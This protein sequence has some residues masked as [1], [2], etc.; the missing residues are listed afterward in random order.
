MRIK[1]QEFEV[2]PGDP[3]QSDKLNRKEP[4]EILTSLIKSFKGPCVLAVDAEWGHGKTTFLRFWMQYLRDKKFPVI[5]FNAWETDYSDDPLLSLT[6]EL[7]EGLKEL[8]FNNI[9]LKQLNKKGNELLKQSVMHNS[10]HTLTKGI[11]NP[12]ALIDKRVQSYK[13]T[14]QSVTD[15]K[16]TLAK[17]ADESISR[18][19]KPL[20]IAIDELDRCRPPYAVELLE[21][22]KHLFDLDNIIFILA[23]NRSQLSQSIKVL[24]GN[25]FDSQE[26]L[27]RFFD[28]D[29]C[30]PTPDRTDFV[31]S[32]II[33]TGFYD[34]LS[35]PKYPEARQQ[36]HRILMLLRSLFNIYDISLRDI[37]QAM[38]RLGVLLNS[39]RDY[40]RSFLIGMITA[41]IIRTF[42]PNIYHQFRTGEVEDVEVIDALFNARG[43]KLT[44]HYSSDENLFYASSL[45]QAVV[46][47]ATISRKTQGRNPPS[48][49]RQTSQLLDRYKNFIS[50]YDAQN[51]EGSEAQ[52]IPNSEHKTANEVIN[53]VKQHMASASNIIDY[54]FWISTKHLE[55]ISPELDS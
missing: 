45:L 50:M 46:I 40:P 25:D 18:F 38:Y 3:F 7:T 42:A 8:N 26:Y 9:L 54:G 55:L 29:F 13:R 36:Q 48:H 27:R 21:V 37:E 15:F 6:S 28:I 53:V 11:I 51:Y 22:T 47:L 4:I 35:D 39:L 16:A 52:A 2:P 5:Q 23:V 30:L 20:I 41:L 1:P 44:A 33:S 14:K 43:N 17:T 49:E 34:Y 19:S 24:Y 12:A 10:I 32:L 31:D